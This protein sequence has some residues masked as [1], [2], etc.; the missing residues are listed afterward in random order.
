[1][2]LSEAWANTQVRPYSLSKTGIIHLNK[3]L[4]KNDDL[5]RK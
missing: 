1:M 3:S 2:P 4:E 5:S